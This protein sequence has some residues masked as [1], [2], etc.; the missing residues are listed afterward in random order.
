MF[1]RG[2]S[3]RPKTPTQIP[4]R[5][6]YQFP[7]DRR[8]WATL[9]FTVKVALRRQ[10]TYFCGILRRVAD[11]WAWPV[12]LVPLDSHNVPR[13]G[14]VRGRVVD[15][16]CEVLFTAV[17]GQT[18]SALR[19]SRAFHGCGL[20]SPFVWYHSIATTFQ[21]AVPPPSPP[22]PSPPPPP[23]PPTCTRCSCAEGAMRLLPHGNALAQTLYETFGLACGGWA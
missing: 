20:A 23:S 4:R 13:A 12:R 21:A 18:R 16:R 3:G 6:F 10:G 17:G 5:V 15:G 19:L 11:A 8:C 1:C 2:C 9:P 14:V 7:T 22:L